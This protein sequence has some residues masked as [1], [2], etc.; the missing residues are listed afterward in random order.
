MSNSKFIKFPSIEKFSDVNA[1]V[2][3]RFEL[4]QRPTV[5]Y[6]AKTKLHGT[7][8]SIRIDHDGSITCG[9]RTGTCSV[10][11]DNAGFANWVETVKGEFPVRETPY[12]IFGEWAGPGIQ[13]KVAISSIPKKMFF[14]FALLDITRD[15][16]WLDPFQIE[17]FL[18]GAPV[19]IMP[20]AKDTNVEIDFRLQSSMEAAMSQIG[21]MVEACD[22]VD[23]YVKEYFGIEGI[24]EGYV[25]TPFKDSLRFADYHDYIFKA[26]GK[27]HAVAAHETTNRIQVD[28]AI[29]E[30]AAAFA[31]EFVTPVR[32]E[33]ALTEACGGTASMKTIG[34]FM[35]WIGA[36]VKK[37]SVNEL[38]ASGLEWKNVA[39]AVNQQAREWFILATERS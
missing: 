8:A 22:K 37:E 23:P 27:S 34:A 12:V 31:K 29:L 5:Q 14:V 35:G 21:N 25:F 32:C 19:K 30:G 20:W 17:H 24:G 13:K 10:Q 1:T 9:K 38:E 39:K 36:D 18:K 11:D 33:Q 4:D 28:P 16:I 15:E 6:K 7:N 2:K 3:R 26:K